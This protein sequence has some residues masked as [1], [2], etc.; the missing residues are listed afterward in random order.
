M[1]SS[2]D[3]VRLEVSY[4]SLPDTDTM[5]DVTGMDT[6]TDGGLEGGMSSSLGDVPLSD[7]LPDTG[8]TA[9]EVT[10]PTSLTGSLAE[11]GIPLQDITNRSNNDYHDD[12]NGDVAGSPQPSPKIGKCQS[13]FV[14]HHASISTR[15]RL[16][17]QNSYLFS[18]YSVSE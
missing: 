5:T 7:G 18:A 4:T 1:D 17:H 16:Y 13:H 8:V 14:Y 6:T 11:Q 2:G 12:A 3:R 9:T 15:L 10:T